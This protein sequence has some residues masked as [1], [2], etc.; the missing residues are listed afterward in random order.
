MEF[1]QDPRV[2]AQVTTLIRRATRRPLIIKLTPNVTRI[3]DIARAAKGSGANAVSLINTLVGMAVDVNTRR[4]KINTVTGG[5]SGPA[6]K[7]VA[8]AKVYEVAQQVDI[9]IVGIGGIMNGRDALEFLITG[10]TAIQVG[11]ANFIDPRTSEKIISE[12]KEYCQREGV[13]AIGEVIGTLRTT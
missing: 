4:A 3:S 10:A 7:P 2:T 11:T 8:L 9:P 6:V 12:L 5:Y 1:S 13:H